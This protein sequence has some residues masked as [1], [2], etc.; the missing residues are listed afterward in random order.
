MVSLASP[1]YIGDKLL[2]VAGID[3]TKG[4]LMESMNSFKALSPSSNI[5]IFD[6]KETF[7][8]GS[9]K[10]S[11]ELLGYISDI[12]SKSSIN[13]TN[14]ISYLKNK[15]I[16]VDDRNSKGPFIVAEIQTNKIYSNLKFILLGLFGSCIV[17]FL[18]LI[19][20]YIFS[21]KIFQEPE[22]ILES[23]TTQKEEQ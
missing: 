20:F 22:L 16:L 19:I 9:E 21:F 8:A 15:C 4:R 10:P 2:G 11:K 12:R 6:S 13:K 3:T 17:L 7:I 5:Y 23:E 14:Y 18:F 1:V